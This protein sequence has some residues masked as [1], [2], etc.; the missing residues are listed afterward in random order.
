MKVLFVSL[1][2][3]LAAGSAFGQTTASPKQ[4]EPTVVVVKAARLLDVRK[5]S[6]VENAAVLVEADVPQGMAEAST[7]FI[8][9]G[10]E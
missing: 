9:S 1:A 3:F 7:G 10:G 4:A 6:Y 8:P 5:G 2:L